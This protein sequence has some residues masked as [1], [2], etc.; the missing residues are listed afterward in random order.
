[1]LLQPPLPIWR[2]TLK[3]VRKGSNGLRLSMVVSRVEIANRNK[4][5]NEFGGNNS[6]WL[7]HFLKRHAKSLVES[8]T[9]G[10]RSSSVS[11]VLSVAKVR[12]VPQVLQIPLPQMFQH[13]QVNSH[14][15][16][17]GRGRTQP[18]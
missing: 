3:T 12:D 18:G 15:A 16:R 6:W 13:S 10:V 1:M 7:I 11:D 8:L 4:Q 5:F 2:E 14:T 9:L 17:P